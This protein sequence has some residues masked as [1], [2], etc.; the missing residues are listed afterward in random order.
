MSPFYLICNSWYNWQ[1]SPSPQP[2]SKTVTVYCSQTAALGGLSLQDLASD[3]W[4]PSSIQ[5]GVPNLWCLML[6]DLSW[7]WCNKNRN[8]VHNKCSVLESSWT[9]AT[10]PPP[11]HPPP[12]H[13]HLFSVH[14]KTAFHKISPWCQKVWGLCTKKILISLFLTLGFLISLKAE[15]IQD[16]EAHV[17]RSNSGFCSCECKS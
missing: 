5:P 6:A 7:S 2:Q 8:K 4:A 15:L 9:T 1:S 12:P 11:P 17:A 10:A 13:T 14:E 16:L 3:R